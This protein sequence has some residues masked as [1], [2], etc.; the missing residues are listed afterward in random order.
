MKKDQ[1][2]RDQL[3]P[4][5]KI[6]GYHASYWDGD[7]GSGQTIHLGYFTD[8]IAANLAAHKK[9]YWGNN[10]D[11]EEITLYTDGKRLYKVEDLGLPTNQEKDY[12]EKMKN[13]ITSKLTSEELQFLKSTGL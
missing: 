4:L 13:T 7:Y 2:L 12:H 3:P 5:I 6:Q 9:G 8:E 11:V 10:A 1:E